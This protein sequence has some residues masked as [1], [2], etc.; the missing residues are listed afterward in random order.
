MAAAPRPALGSDRACDMGD[1]GEKFISM[2][3][4]NEPRGAWKLFC[5]EAPN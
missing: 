1:G 5:Q 3:V 4:A 2:S